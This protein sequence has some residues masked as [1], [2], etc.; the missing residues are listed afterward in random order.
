MSGKPAQVL[1]PKVPGFDKVLTK[2]AL[3]FLTELH[4]RFN[5]TRKQLLAAR[6]KR[7]ALLD[8]GEVPTFLKVEASRVS[9]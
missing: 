8:K 4:R 5:Y 1:G 6:V 9:A 3:V 7:Q 2:E